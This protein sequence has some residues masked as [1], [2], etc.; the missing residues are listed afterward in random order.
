VR[1]FCAA[2]LELSPAIVVLGGYI[3]QE[4]MSIVDRLLASLAI[5]D[6]RRP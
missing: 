3:P 1:Q 5:G 6:E 2:I 4:P